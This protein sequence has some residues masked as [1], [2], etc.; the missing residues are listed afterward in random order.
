MK[1]TF[2]IPEDTKQIIELEFG[3]KV[4]E[5]LEKVKDDIIDKQEKGERLSVAMAAKLMG[6]TQ[7][8]LRVGIQMGKL[9]FGWA[10]KITG[11][12]RYTYYISPKKFTE[13]T[14]I[15]VPK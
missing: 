9:P 7:Q 1:Y 6:V 15:E 8:F 12:N 13:C 14:G 10:V 5:Y 11:G 3:M 2:S 4:D